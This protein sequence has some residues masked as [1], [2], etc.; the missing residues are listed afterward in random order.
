MKTRWKTEFETGREQDVI[1][2]RIIR[3]ILA[4]ANYG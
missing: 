2:Q 3:E 4:K 1:V